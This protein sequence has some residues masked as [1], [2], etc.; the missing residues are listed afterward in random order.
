MVFVDLF[1]P[2]FEILGQQK[3]SY[4]TYPVMT[5]PDAI[6]AMEQIYTIFNDSRKTANVKDIIF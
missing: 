4:T 1:I 6:F 2:N 5:N 3:N